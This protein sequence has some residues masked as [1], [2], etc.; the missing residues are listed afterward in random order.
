MRG[1]LSLASVRAPLLGGGETEEP[2]RHLADAPGGTG[3]ARPACRTPLL[4]EL[5]ALWI[6]VCGAVRFS[7]AKRPFSGAIAVGMARLAALIRNFRS[8]TERNNVD[9]GRFSISSRGGRRLL[10]A[11]GGAADTR[12]GRCPGAGPGRRRRKKAISPG[13]PASLSAGLFAYRALVVGAII[14]VAASDIAGSTVPC[15][16]KPQRLA[17]RGI[18]PGP[19]SGPRLT[20]LRHHVGIEPHADLF[21]IG[22]RLRSPAAP[23]DKGVAVEL[24]GLGQSAEPACLF[25][26]EG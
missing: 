10:V 7:R 4:G 16:L 5:L 12:K 17:Q 3:C 1:L 6:A 13:G 11:A 14:G 23:P 9:Q 8:K 2:W 19:P 20:E 18:D 26:E 22:V 25:V 24:L 15:R 21:L